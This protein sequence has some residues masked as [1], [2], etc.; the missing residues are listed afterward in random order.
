LSAFARVFDAIAPQRIRDARLLDR[1][2]Q[3]IDTQPVRSLW[4]AR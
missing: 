1:I 4:L 3:H 2:D